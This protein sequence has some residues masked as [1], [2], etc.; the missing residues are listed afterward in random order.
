MLHVYGTP[1]M[2]RSLCRTW[3]VDEKNRFLNNIKEFQQNFVDVDCANYICKFCLNNTFKYRE[4]DAKM[5]YEYENYEIDR[6]NGS[7]DV[8]A[9]HFKLLEDFV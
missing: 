7:E 6:K 5:F 8:F 1:Y 3:L 2:W 9:L 4:I